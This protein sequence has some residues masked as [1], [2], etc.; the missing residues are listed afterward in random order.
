MSLEV[1]VLGSS[2]GYAGAGKA[3]SG[4]LLRHGEN[5]LMLDIGSGSLANLLVQL[6][7]DGLGGLAITHMH[8]DHYV[9]IYGLAT[10]R[11][12]WESTLPPLPLLAPP[13]AMDVIGS[14][15]SDGSRT[16]FFECF[17]VTGHQA[18]ETREIAGFELV[19]LPARHITGSFSFRVTAGGRTVCYSGDTDV[20]DSLLQLAGGVDLFICESTFTSEVP[21]KEPGH[22]YAR[23]AGDM[24]TR[25]GAGSLLLTHLW[26]TLDGRRALEDA[27]SNYKGP[28]ELA[29]EGQTLEV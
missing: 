22:L 11:R 10:A 27:R 18:G 7:A 2:G 4:Y 14:P 3:C 12:F 16:R 24:A 26:P 29:L 28:I 23:E 15:L 6:P 13:G 5:S 21:N 19:A 17:E 20:C 1:T 9:D 25:A 8:Y